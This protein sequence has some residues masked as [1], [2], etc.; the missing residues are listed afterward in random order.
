M[1]FEDFT[2]DYVFDSPGRTIAE[3]DIMEFARLTGDFSEIHTNDDRAKESPFGRRIAHG[4]LVFSISIGITVSSGLVD[5]SLVAFYGVDGLRFT[6]PVFIGDAVTVQKRV[7]ALEVKG[8]GRGMVTFRTRV[9]NQDG[10]PVLVY[11]DSLLLRTR[12]QPGTPD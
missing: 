4:A 5:D 9:L 12:D 1:F 6:R 3:G 8:Q 10:R 2:L 7:H 11:R